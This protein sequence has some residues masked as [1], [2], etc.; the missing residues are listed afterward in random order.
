MTPEELEKR[1]RRAE[2]F[3]IPET[4]PAP[5]V[6]GNAPAK[7]IDPEMAKKLEE[8]EKRFKSA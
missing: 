6:K 5:A 1:K 2:R 8:R 7:P 4:A 3:G